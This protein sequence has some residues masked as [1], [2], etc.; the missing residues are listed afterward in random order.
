MHVV[1]RIRYWRDEMGIL[2]NGKSIRDCFTFD[3][4]SS[5]FRDDAET[6]LWAAVCSGKWGIQSPRY[7]ESN[8]LHKRKERSDVFCIKT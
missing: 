7:I 6:N 8:A 3:L 2:H 1:V 4:I 5:E